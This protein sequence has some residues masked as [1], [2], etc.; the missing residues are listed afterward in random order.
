MNFSSTIV[1]AAM[2][3]LS[4]Q[5]TSDAIT[6][7]RMAVDT[8]LDDTH[9]YSHYVPEYHTA[10]V[11]GSHE[12]HGYEV[13]KH[14]D[15]DTYDYDTGLSKHVTYKQHNPKDVFADEYDETCGVKAYC[16]RFAQMLARDH[17]GKMYEDH[18]VMRQ[19]GAQSNHLMSAYFVVPNSLVVHE[20]AIVARLNL[21][22][23]EYF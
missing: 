16:S 5:A 1:A 7:H 13:K 9:A 18:H 3:G 22:E 2:L 17:R 10:Y 6:A 8:L 15:L 19:N 12:D 14:A 23:H 20:D 21:H 4:A 11:H